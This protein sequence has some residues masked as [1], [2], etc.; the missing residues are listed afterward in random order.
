MEKNTGFWT[1]YLL[2]LIMFCVGIFTLL[3]GKKLYVVRPPKGG[4]IVNAFRALW[5]GLVNRCNM[6]K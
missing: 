2:C 1:A 5:V 4:V 6:G 3:A